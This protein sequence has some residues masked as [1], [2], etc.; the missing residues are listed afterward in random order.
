MIAKNLTFRLSMVLASVVLAVLLCLAVFKYQANA[1]HFGCNTLS[2]PVTQV[3][4][5]CL[6]H[7]YYTDLEVVPADF[8]RVATSGDYSSDVFYWGTGPVEK[9]DF[10]KLDA[11]IAKVRGELFWNENGSNQEQRAVYSSAFFISTM[12]GR[13]GT[14]Y[15]SLN[16]G[17]TW[18]RTNVD[19]WEANF[20]E[21]AAQGRV[22]WTIET[23]PF[24]EPT[25]GLIFDRTSADPDANVVDLQWIHNSSAAAH[26]TLRIDN[27]SGP[28]YV[29]KLDCGNLTGPTVSGFYDVPQWSIDNAT[30]SANSTSQ[31]WAGTNTNVSYGVTNNGPGRTT[32]SGNVGVVDAYL[33]VTRSDILGMGPASG[34]IAGSQ[35]MNLDVGPR[36]WSLNFS[37]PASA[38][39]GQ[40]YCFRVQFSP[41]AGYTGGSVTNNSSEDTAETCIQVQDF[42]YFKVHGSGVHNGA[43]WDT[44]N[45]CQN[46]THTIGATPPVE[47]RILSGIGTSAE[48]GVTSL[49]SEVNG[50][51]SAIILN[52][53]I[54]TRDRLTFANTDDD[55]L[56]KFLGDSIPASPAECL[57]DLY[58]ELDSSSL[59]DRPIGQIATAG[60]YGAA[61]D[62]NK[63]AY[64]A[65]LQNGNLTGT[66][67]FSGKAVV[68]VEGDMNV[69]GDVT[70][71]ANYGDYASGIKIPSLVFVVKGDII[72]NQ[73]VSRLDG[74]YIAIPRDDG[75]GGNIVTCNQT[76]GT[77]INNPCGNTQLTVNGGFIS[78][79]VDFY[80]FI[81]GGQVARNSAGAQDAYASEIFNFSP[82]L[83]MAKPFSGLINYNNLSNEHFE[84][85]KER[86]PVY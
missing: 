68:L 10:Q 63:V 6:M 30:P 85:Y 75:S 79:D 66:A 45:R 84:Y 13:Y 81:H 82:E 83:Y 24:T 61:E 65:K 29:L 56:G 18:S 62:V 48:Y 59:P 23:F 40:E 54:A 25:S 71:S 28:D 16:A 5:R 53:N 3:Y 80:R 34:P 4:N 14:D 7:G 17:L 73:N 57:T 86:A 33:L 31:V 26:P 52:Q 51:A 46:V 15:G 49:T 69:T 42:A 67:N 39:V 74:L 22:N 50:F 55:E 32:T 12:M 2:Y 27:I 20:R 60:T 70:Y 41:R 43:V 37:V 58:D 78:S 38:Q 9:L 35:N 36:T 1:T 64:L 44:L 21:M 19:V 72:M 47:S 8:A 77:Q 76:N 11:F